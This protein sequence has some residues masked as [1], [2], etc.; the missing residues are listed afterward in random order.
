MLAILDYDWLI[1]TVGYACEKR[2]IEVTRKETGQKKAFKNVS[3]FW[4]RKKNVI[5]GWLGEQNSIL[6][7]NGKEP[8][9]KDDF[10]VETIRVA[11]DLPNALHTAKVMIND[12]LQK[13]D[14]DEY[15]G[16]IGKG[17]T[18]RHELATIYEYKGNRPPEKPI[19][20]EDIEKYLLKNHN[21][22][23]VEGIEADDQ[24]NIMSIEHGVDN[25]VVIAVDKDSAGNP[26]RTFNPNRPDKGIVDGRCFGEIEIVEKG[27]KGKEY[28]DVQGHGRKFFYFQCAYGDDVDN[29]RANS[30]SDLDW[31][32]ISAYNALNHATNDREALYALADIYQTL[33]PEPKKIIGWRGDTLEIDWFYVLRENWNLARM[34]RWE[35]DSVDVEAIFKRYGIL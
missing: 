26:V 27:T 22:Y 25:S 20:R 33:Y 10:E 4:G 18:F 14:A 32:V 8:Y 28:K 19:L 31:G 13:V 6:I 24:L 16:Y 2:T 9:T 7:E 23:Y 3:E 5:E 12:V 30:A 21:G 29:Y 17:K 1:Y 34:L 35:G 15:I 11:E